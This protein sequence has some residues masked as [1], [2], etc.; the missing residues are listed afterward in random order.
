MLLVWENGNPDLV[1]DIK[2]GAAPQVPVQ[3]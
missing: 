2:S 1:D 3:F